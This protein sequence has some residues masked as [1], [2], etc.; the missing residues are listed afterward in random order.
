LILERKAGVKCLIIAAGQGRRLR[1]RSH[2]KPLV[3][4]LG[5]PLIERVIR[6]AM[7]GG[8]EDFLVVSGYNGP[9]VRRLLDDLSQR[10]AV[11]IAH[12]V[13]DDWQAANGLSVLKAKDHCREP[14][15]LLMADHLFDPSIVR[16]LT[17]QARGEGGVILAVDGN[18]DNPLVDRKDVT[19]VRRDGR[20]IFDIGKGCRD[21]NALDTGIFLCTPALFGAIERS[22]A[23][24]DD[25][26]LSGGMRTLAAEGKLNCFDIEGRFWLDVDDPAALRRAEDA[27][28]SEVRHKPNDGP[29][30][31]HVNRPLSVRLSRYLARWSVTPNQIS[32]FSFLLSI[33][34][35]WLLS[36]GT[37]AGLV[38]GGI[39][40]QCASVIDGCDGEIARLKFHESEFGGWF[41]AVLDR[42]ADAILLFGLT[43]HAYTTGTP[44]VA[45]IAG[46]LAII[47]SFMVSYT[48]DKYDSL[49]QARINNGHV[50]RLGRDVRVFLIFVGALANQVLATLLIIAVIMNAETLRR[51]V[52]CAK[53]R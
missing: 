23:Q 9:P 7:Q 47:G 21:G 25:A 36:R 49:M 1:Q 34:A 51:V 4:I 39:L 22:I 10:C 30:A 27:L 29:I 41:D 45:L 37:Y 11:D 43:W 33:V 35:A 19:W 16:D 24:H 38:S 8:V 40:A 5:V 12:I 28:L 31:R 18:T 42:Y 53:R 6:A 13:N 52:V 3:P 20:K 14:F 32:V 2:S 46:F 26:S 15:L 50:F 48:A 44:S 17:Q